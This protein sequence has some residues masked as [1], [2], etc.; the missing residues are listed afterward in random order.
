MAAGP[1][2]KVFGDFHAGRIH[3]DIAHD[4]QREMRRP[5]VLGMKGLDL[6]ERRDLCGSDELLERMRPI[7]ISRGEHRT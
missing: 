6:V 4:D 2:R 1:P 7:R 3:R 5:I